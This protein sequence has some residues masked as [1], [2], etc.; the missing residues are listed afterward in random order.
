MNA[1][2]KFQIET[3]I[4]ERPP[5]SLLSVTR[6]P[7]SAKVVLLDRRVRLQPLPGPSKHIRFL[8]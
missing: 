3:T 4:S 8:A 6:S 2:D 1:G 7:D 5:A